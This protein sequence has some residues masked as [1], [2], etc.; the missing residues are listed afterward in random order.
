MGEG[1]GG[2]GWRGRGVEGEREATNGVREGVV[3]SETIQG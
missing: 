1:E 2:T 3:L